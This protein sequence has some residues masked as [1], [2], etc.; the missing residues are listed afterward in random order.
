MVTYSSTSRFKK[1][2]FVSVGLAVC[3]SASTASL[4]IAVPARASTTVTQP[5]VSASV[6]DSV[7]SPNKSAPRYLTGYSNECEKRMRQRNIGRDHVNRVVEENWKKAWIDRK[8]GNWQYQ[9][10]TINVSVSDSGTCVT[11]FRLKK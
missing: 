4:G 1:A 8:N 3:F 11:V 7:V 9:D 10:K 5:T 6:K 2:I